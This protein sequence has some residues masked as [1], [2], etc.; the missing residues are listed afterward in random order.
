MNV[1]ALVVVALVQL[2]SLD[3]QPLRETIEAITTTL[4]DQYVEPG[5]GGRVGRAVTDEFPW[6]ES[7]PPPTPTR[8][9]AARVQ[10][11]RAGD[12]T[13]RP[14]VLRRGRL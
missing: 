11:K 12:V 8:F 10:T 14:F 2:V 9:A 6:A 4:V 7:Q 3:L 1:L 13:R 5:E